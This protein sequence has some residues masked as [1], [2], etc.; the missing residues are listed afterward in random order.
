M[1]AR[2]AATGI[3]CFVSPWGE[4]GRQAGLYEQAV[5]VADVYPAPAPT[6]YRR[7]GPVLPRACTAVM[8]VWV[9]A[10]VWRR[11]VSRPG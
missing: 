2:A 10:A 7:V 6:L 5:L 3:S 11:R 1:R 8:A 4:M 9:I